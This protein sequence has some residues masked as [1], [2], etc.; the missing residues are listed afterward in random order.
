MSD[1]VDTTGGAH[2]D[3]SDQSFAAGDQ[4]QAIALVE[5]HGLE[6]IER[7]QMSS[8]LGLIAKLPPTAATGR[9]RLQ[10]AEAGRTCS[11]TIPT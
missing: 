9:P 7:S 10:L 8:L 6:L 11:C 1:H 4:N 2:D 5:A 3:S